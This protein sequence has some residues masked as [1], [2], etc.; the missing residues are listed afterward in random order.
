MIFFEMAKI[1]IAVIHSSILPLNFNRMAFN[2]IAI[3]GAII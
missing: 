3:D 2:I 1:R